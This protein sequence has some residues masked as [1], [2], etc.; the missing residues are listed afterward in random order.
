MSLGI[1]ETDR[2]THHVLA[3]AGGGERRGVELLMRRA[4]GMDHQRLG[5]ADIGEMGDQLQAVDEAPAGGAAA[6][7]AEA[8]DRASAARQQAPGQRVVGMARQLRMEH[9]GDGVGF[10]QEVEHAA[11]VGH[12]LRHAQRQGL[13]PLE[14]L[15]GV[16]RA[17][18]GA[19]IAQALGAGAHDEGLRPELRGEIDAVIAGIGLAQGRELARRLPVEAPAIDQRA[20]DGDAV[21][22][23]PF[24]RGMHDDVAAMLDRPAEIGRGEG[25]IDQQRQARAMRHRRHRRDVEHLEAGIAEDLGE[26]EPRLGPDRRGEGGG[27]AGIDEARGDAEARQRQLQQVD[28]AAIERGGRDDVAARPHQGGDGEMQRRLAARG[29]DRADA[30]LERREPLLEHGDGGIGD[31]RIDVAGLL[32][33]EERGGVVAVA[34]DVARRLIDRHGARAGDGIGPL[35]GMER[36]RGKF[37]KLGVGHGGSAQRR[38]GGLP[39]TKRGTGLYPLPGSRHHRGA[40]LSRINLG[41]ARCRR[42][43]YPAT[44]NRNSGAGQCS[45]IVASPSI[46]TATS[47]RRNRRRRRRRGGGAGGKARPRA[48]PRGAVPGNL[49]PRPARRRADARSRPVLSTAIAKRSPIG[50]WVRLASATIGACRARRQPKEG[51]EPSA[52]DGP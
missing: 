5:V 1:L 12:V 23:Q 32:E 35:P 45:L 22:A 26:D 17:H 40:A 47:Q 36:Q 44:G 28:R 29:A 19:E 41:A 9:P 14:K 13:D 24:G 20:A 38:K 15:E 8:D 3:D 49:A 21:A 2:K 43:I 46:A 39:Y 37:G 11:R 50:F 31:A 4:G 51:A 16:G 7:D 27:V 30:A 42:M 34:E 52:S 33:I 48:A 10:G 25:G 6:L 18:A